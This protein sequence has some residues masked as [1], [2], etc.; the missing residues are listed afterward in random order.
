M[1]AI[2]ESVEITLKPFYFSTLLGLQTAIVAL[3]PH[4]MLVSWQDVIGDS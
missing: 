1:S 3:V 2:V 4:H